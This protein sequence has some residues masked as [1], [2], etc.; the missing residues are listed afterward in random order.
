MLRLNGLPLKRVNRRVGK[1]G[2]WPKP[3]IKALLQDVII[4]FL[5]KKVEA[6]CS[7]SWLTLLGRGEQG[8]QSLKQRPMVPPSP[9]CGDKVARH[10]QLQY[11][12]IQ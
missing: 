4:L 11:T 10:Q 8:G 9:A 1:G 3:A 5:I 12:L 6:V 2:L 7:K